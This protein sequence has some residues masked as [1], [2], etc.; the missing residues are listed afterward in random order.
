MS[1][2]ADFSPTIV[3]PYAA[4]QGNRFTP[5]EISS[6]LAAMMKDVDYDGVPNLL[7]YAFGG[8]PK[9]PDA[10]LIAAVCRVISSF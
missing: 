1:S 5:V 8:N 9:L 4:W 3:S 2:T 6:G 10:A 7:E